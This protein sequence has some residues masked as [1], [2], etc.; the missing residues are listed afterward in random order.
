MGRKKDTSGTTTAPGGWQAVAAASA[1]K[2][3]PRAV[4]TRLD[5]GTDVCTVYESIDIQVPVSDDEAALLNAQAA[6][7]LAEAEVK[8]KELESR[9]ETMIKPL[10]AEIKDLRKDASKAATEA[11]ERKRTVNMRIRV[12][13]HPSTATVRFLH[14]DTGKAVLLERAMTPLELENYSQAA[15][16][17]SDERVDIAGTEATS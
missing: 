2:D 3:K 12:E 7:A 8:Q 11:G 4:Q 16:P 15:D 5:L 9:R 13:Y 1:A 17:P 14:P 10:E 6:E